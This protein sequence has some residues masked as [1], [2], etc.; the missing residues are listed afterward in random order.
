MK[1]GRSFAIV[2]A[3]GR[4]RRMGT[5]K[6]LLPWRHHTIVQEVL[7]RWKAAGVDH[8]VVVVHPADAEL[9]RL[10]REAG[11]EVVVAAVPPPDMKASV[12]LGLEYVTARWQ[13]QATDA[14]LLAPADMPELS[15]Q[16]TRSLL[17]EHAA[18]PEAIVVPTHDS[19]GGHPVLFPWPLAAAVGQ[20][21]ADQGVNALLDRGPVTL[22]PCDLP[23]AADIDTPDEY[24]QARRASAGDG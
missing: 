10:A 2:P 23:R 14:W 24:A 12:R 15:P 5:P 7:Q 13:P 20:L 21:D 3:A 17:A 4:S 22:L 6:L 18:R 19:R 8:R 16:V 11:A 1:T 9:A